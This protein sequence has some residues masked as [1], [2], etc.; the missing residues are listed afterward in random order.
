MTYTIH[1][2]FKSFYLNILAN[3]YL[4]LNLIFPY[5]DDLIIT[6]Q[7]KSLINLYKG[8]SCNEIKKKR[9]AQ[10]MNDVY[11][12]VQEYTVLI[13]E[14]KNIEFVKNDSDSENTESEIEETNSEVEESMDTDSSKED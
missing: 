8:T 11:E 14:D 9:F 1:N 7:K 5:Y 12:L 4:C 10:F 6:L 3:F 2:S 13:T